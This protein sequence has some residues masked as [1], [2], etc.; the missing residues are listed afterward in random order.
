MMYKL[1]RNLTMDQIRLAKRIAD[2]CSAE[3]F[4]SMVDS[5]FQDLPSVQLSPDEMEVLKGGEKSC[6]CH[7]STTSSMEGNTY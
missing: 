5:G 3:D 4:Q 2:E 7:D 1:L 6:G